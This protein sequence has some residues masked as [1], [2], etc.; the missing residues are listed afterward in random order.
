[1]K[2]PCFLLASFIL[3][4]SSS[5]FSQDNP[6]GIDGVV[7]EASNFEY[8]PDFLMVEPGETV[9][10]VNMGG[11]HDVNGVSSTIGAAWDNPETFSLN[12]VIGSAEGVCIGAHTFTVEGVYNYDCSIGSHAENG[13][14]ATIQVTQPKP[15][16][17]TVWDIIV[18]SEN[19]TFFESAVI[20]AGLDVALS[21]DGPLTVFAPTD[22][23]I[24][25][26]A[27]T[28]EGLLASEFLEEIVLYHVVG[29]LAMSGDFEDNQILTTL[30]GGDVTVTLPSGML[31]I[32]GAMVITP[33]LSADNG[34]VH[35]I[36]AV[37]LP[38]IPFS[39]TET[40]GHME[41]AVF[42]NPVSDGVLQLTGD[43]ELGSQLRILDTQ[44]RVI[45]QEIL[46]S[47]QLTWD[48]STWPVG[49]YTLWV[50]S[51]ARQQSQQFIVH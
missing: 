30:E 17:T 20:A 42:P 46:R 18:E 25:S 10:W 28:L 12:S 31:H 1:M 22:A 33:D 45:E 50:V 21:G 41:I 36:N 51:E 3:I 2:C 15:P 40:A 6:C 47:N 24:E 14:V 7:V 8:A 34:V 11:T 13:M 4:C 44:G 32:N 37:L 19:H 43:W 9:V 5:V 23:A 26:M 27:Q 29:A 39:V 48:I 38:S 16:P 49:V 35:V